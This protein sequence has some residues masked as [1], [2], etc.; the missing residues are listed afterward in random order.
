MKNGVIACSDVY[1]RSWSVYQQI[2]LILKFSIYHG[3]CAWIVGAN[4][5]QVKM[6][7]AYVTVS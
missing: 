4:G 1:L 6:V 2:G 5:C 7:A 3:V